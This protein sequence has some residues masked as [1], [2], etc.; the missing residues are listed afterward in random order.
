MRI[1]ILGGK[2]E[3]AEVMAIL[4]N[5]TGHE[6]SIYEQGNLFLES[7]GAVDYDLFIVD[8]GFPADSMDRSMISRIR[9]A[10]GRAQPVLLLADRAWNDDNLA[11]ALFAGADGYMNKPVH[12]KEMAARV[13]AL[14][15]RAYP[16]SALPADLIRVGDYQLDSVG[17]T[18]TLRGNALRLSRREFD[19]GQYFFRNI[20][21][22]VPRV[23]LETAVWG[24]ELGIDSKTLDTHVYRLRL[25]LQLQPENGLQLSSVYAQGFRL[26]PVMAVAAC[27]GAYA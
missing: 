15:R 25:K 27:Q 17:R 11:A 14:L 9:A 13:N 22:L 19:L 16:Q 26:T 18:V 12:M 3:Q 7:G 23:V 8:S 24:R 20:G 4:L 5:G 10:A 1:A 6:C 21:R 2:R